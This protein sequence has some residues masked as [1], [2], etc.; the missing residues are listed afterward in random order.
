MNDHGCRGGN[1]ISSSQSSSSTTNSHSSP[2]FPM[3]QQQQQ[4][5]QQFPN[6]INNTSTPSTSIAALLLPNNGGSSNNS[7]EIVVPG[8]L[9]IILGR[10]RHPKNSMGY[11]KF[12]NLIDEYVETYD[13]AEKFSDNLFMRGYHEAKFG[14]LTEKGFWYVFVNYSNDP[15]KIR[16]KRDELRKLNVF[17]EAWVLE[18]TEN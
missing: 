2:I 14:Y 13:N 9:D 12:R 15:V 18:V 8:P 1:I 7:N 6:I 11:M 16:E 5:I 10:G 3:L 4:L 17:K